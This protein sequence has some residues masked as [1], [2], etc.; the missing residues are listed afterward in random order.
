MTLYDIKNRR[1]ILL[2]LALT[3]ITAAAYLPAMYSGGFVWD[4]DDY[5]IHNQ[6]LRD[7]GGLWQIWTS[8]RA[9]PQYYPLVH[10][11]Y[12]VEYRLWGLVP[13]GYHVTNVLL[14]ALAAVLVWRVLR[15]LEVPGAWLAAALFAVHP[16]HVESVAWITERKNVLS[17]VFYLGAALAYLK[18]ADAKAGGDRRPAAYLTAFILFL[19]ALLSKTVAATL[20]AALL[21]VMWWKGGFENGSRSSTARPDIRRVWGQVR[22]LVPFFVAGLALS[23]LTVW[24]EKHHVGAEGSQWHLSF[25]DRCLIAGRAL[26]F[27]VGK[28]LW[29]LN[30]CFNYPRWEIDASAWRQYFFPLSAVAVVVL[31]WAARKRI[32]RGPLVAVLFFAGTLLPAL[33][34][35]DVYPM[36]YSFVADHFQYLASI[37][38]LALGSAVIVRGCRLRPLAGEDRPVRLLARGL[39]AGAALVLLAFLSAKQ[40]GIYRNLETLYLD[41]ID[42]NPASW[43]ACNNLGQLY[44]KEGR[45]E[46][47]IP[48]I[49]Q[50]LRHNPKDI[51]SILNLGVALSRLGHEE[52]AMKQYQKALEIDPD[53]PEV[54]SNIGATLARQGRYDKAVPYY[55]KALE[56]KPDFAPTHSNLGAALASLGRIDEA[57]EHHEKALTL[58]PD[59]APSHLKFGETLHLVGRIR[60]AEDRYREAISLDPSLAEAHLN[61][62]LIAVADQLI[63]AALDHFR[64]A[65]K[66]APNF[67]EAHRNLAKTLAAVGRVADAEQHFNRA[68]ALEPRSARVRLDYADFLSKR[69]DPSAARREYLVAAELMP[70]NPEPL[71]KIGVLDLQ[72]RDTVDAEARFR[73]VV[74]RAPNHAPALNHLA[75]LLAG[76][77]TKEREEAA[78]LLRKAVKLDPGNAEYHNNLGVILVRLGNRREALQTLEEAVRLKPDYDEARKNRDD[79]RRLLAETKGAP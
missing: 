6:T 29:P 22:P 12:W 28:L 34:F 32:G 79:L 43:M 46:D 5:V 70:D 78:G 11:T 20:P 57:I 9:T 19:G 21:L 4:D 14:H 72:L 48:L 52:Q 75:F 36:R 69:G 71:F 41:T 8:P 2:G 17:G 27:Y 74:E 1:G 24:L 7:A 10:T 61:L 3:A 35:F 51:D 26:W 25:I 38:V 15:R 45:P 62:G 49:E 37:G 18:W 59:L 54:Y 58:A 68:V 42:K 33:G 16:V 60:E 64:R 66:L 23:C 73:A 63:P 77:G 30:L 31:L 67:A 39:P 44:I 65:A 47:A 56:I 55:R 50:A 76:Q 13:T 53:Q 40:C